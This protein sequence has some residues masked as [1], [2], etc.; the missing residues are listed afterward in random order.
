MRVLWPI[1][2]APAVPCAV[3]ARGGCARGSA[4]WIDVERA[5]HQSREQARVFWFRWDIFWS[6]AGVRSFRS[7]R[8]EQRA[9]VYVMRN[10][11]KSLGLKRQTYPKIAKAMAEIGKPKL[12]I[13]SSGMAYSTRSC[14]QWAAYA[15]RVQGKISFNARY[16]AIRLSQSM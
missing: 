14:R 1:P 11:P 8:P 16:S 2:Y 15:S 7:V 13:F 3:V 9:L 4:P 6:E 5:G 12:K 10:P